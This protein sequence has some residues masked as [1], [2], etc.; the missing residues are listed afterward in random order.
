MPSPATRTASVIATAN[1][2]DGTQQPAGEKPRWGSRTAVPG[3]GEGVAGAQHRFGAR[4]AVV[5]HWQSHRQQVMAPLFF[6]FSC[7]L[8]S[9]T[10]VISCQTAET[11]KDKRTWSW[12]PKC[13]LAL[14]FLCSHA[15]FRIWRFTECIGQNY[16]LI[17]VTMSWLRANSWQSFKLNH[18]NWI[19]LQE[20]NYL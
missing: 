10:L 8:Y 15:C 9:L 7:L 17:A 6:F 4:P 16:H 13:R 1:S 5:P 20:N 19:Q 2:T 14:W 3:A 11:E 18:F 12:T